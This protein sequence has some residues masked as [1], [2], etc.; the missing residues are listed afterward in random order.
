MTDTKTQDLTARTQSMKARTQ[1]FEHQPTRSTLAA[2]SWSAVQH[3]SDP[4]ERRR[5]LHQH[6]NT[7][8]PLLGVGGR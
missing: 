2:R 6:F 1:T 7:F 4:A 3:I 5:A 8:P